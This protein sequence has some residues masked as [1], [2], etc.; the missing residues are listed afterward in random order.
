MI[1]IEASDLIFAVD[2]IPAAL[3]VSSDLFVVYTSNIFA[4]MGLR[5]MYFLLAG[6]RNK[7]YHLKTGVSA[8]LIFVGVKIHRRIVAQPTKDL[9][10]IGL[11]SSPA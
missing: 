4:V 11:L 1:V 6:S 10:F 7:F 9:I 8:V 3:G 5:L 2:S